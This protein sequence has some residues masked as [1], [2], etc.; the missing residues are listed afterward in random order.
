LQSG[1]GLNKD[2][3]SSVPHADG[4]GALAQFL[5]LQNRD[6]FDRIEVAHDVRARVDVF[7]DE[8]VYSDLN[9]SANS[10]SVLACADN[11][12]CADVFSQ[13]SS[14]ISG[15]E[16]LFRRGRRPLH[17][18]YGFLLHGKG[19]SGVLLPLLH[20]KGGSGVLLPLLR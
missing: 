17:I 15:N 13:V 2:K 19:G 7:K 4:F 3:K 18:H 8:V 12:L 10:V 6:E 16:A 14:E 9:E 1:A 11:E 20:G 5:R